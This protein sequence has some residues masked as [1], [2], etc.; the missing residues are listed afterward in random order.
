MASSKREVKVNK[1]VRRNSK[2][3][4][5]QEKMSC[6]VDIKGECL[7]S[8]PLGAYGFTYLIKAKNH[9]G[10]PDDV[11]G[12]IYVGKKAFTHRKKKRLS[13]TARKGTRKKVSI[14]QVDSGWLKY[15][16]SSKPLLED[17]KKYG[18]SMFERRVLSFCANKASLSYDE[19]YWQIQQSVM[20]VPSYNGWISCRIYKKNL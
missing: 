9:P 2:K 13:K 5:P 7:E 14:N 10:L 11:R 12:K 3:E 19:V 6:W 16:G 1:A 18:V 20:L 8:P 15:W 17:I 4:S